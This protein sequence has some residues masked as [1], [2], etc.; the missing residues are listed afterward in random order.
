MEA[1]SLEHGNPNWQLQ[2]TVLVEDGGRPCRLEYAVVCD[3]EWRTLWAR[4]NGWIGATAVSQRVARNQAGEWRQ[5][6]MDCPSVRGCLDIDLAF[7]PITNLLPIRR[8]D[9]AVGNSAPVR[10][11][12]L[13]F[14]DFT[15]ESLEQVYTREASGRYRY[16]SGGG[17]FSASLEVDG[18]GIVSRYGDI[19]QLETIYPGGS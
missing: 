4:V 18:Q 13:R 2:G 17:R 19:W 12:W 10:A 14:P 9:L 1:A 5:N 16:E 15:L 7:T 3:S 11:A 6:G 8:L